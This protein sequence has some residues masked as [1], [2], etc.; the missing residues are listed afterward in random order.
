MALFITD[1]CAHQ[2]LSTSSSVKENKTD[3]TLRSTQILAVR[4]LW[5]THLLTGGSKSDMISP[6]RSDDLLSK[7]SANSSKQTRKNQ[8]GASVVIETGFFSVLIPLYQNIQSIYYFRSHWIC[9]ITLCFIK[10]L[11]NPKF[12]VKLY[13]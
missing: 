8:R 13:A 1:L 6:K 2:C 5:L 3:L 10:F 11:W 4:Q 7:T 12:L 9:I